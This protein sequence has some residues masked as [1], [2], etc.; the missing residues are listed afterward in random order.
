[1]KINLTHHQNQNAKAKK[2]LDV[3]I[4]DGGTPSEVASACYE[5]WSAS[6]HDSACND[7]QAQWPDDSWQ[8][9]FTSTTQE[10]NISD[11]AEDHPQYKADVIAALEA[12]HF[13][14][15]Y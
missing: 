3:I 1:M 11:S 4:A 2:A 5:L 13:K 7:P 14:V 10:V 8:N 12:K 9:H 6:C 15:N